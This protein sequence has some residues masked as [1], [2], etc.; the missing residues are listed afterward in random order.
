MG[1][2]EPQHNLG[3]QTTT[4]QQVPQLL[5]L[6]Q[7]VLQARRMKQLPVRPQQRGFVLRAQLPTLVL[8]ELVR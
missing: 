1:I 6:A 5:Y 4:V 2:P 7:A 3:P 8:V